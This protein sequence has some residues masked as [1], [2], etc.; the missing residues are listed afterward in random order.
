MLVSVAI[1]LTISPTTGTSEVQVKVGLSPLV[2]V[3]VVV[4]AKKVW[5]S[6]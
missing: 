6:P 3:A 4:S 1:M 5:L 2:S